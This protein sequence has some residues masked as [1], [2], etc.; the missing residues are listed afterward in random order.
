MTKMINVQ[1]LRLLSLV[2]ENDSKYKTVKNSQE[3]PDSIIGRVPPIRPLL[4]QVASPAL[5]DKALGVF[6]GEIKVFGSCCWWC[7]QLFDDLLIP[8]GI[9]FLRI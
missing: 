2:P 8:P 6:G 1:Y 4:F 5:S 9:G 7:A 3:E